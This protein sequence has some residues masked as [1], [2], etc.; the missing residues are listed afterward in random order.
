LFNFYEEIDLFFVELFVFLDLKWPYL[1]V[2]WSQLAIFLS[3]GGIFVTVLD[4]VQLPPKLVLSV[5]VNW[6]ISSPRWICFPG[7]VF[8]GH[9]QE[10]FIA[11]PVLLIEDFAI[12]CCFPR[13]RFPGWICLGAAGSPWPARHQQLVHAYSFLPPGSGLVFLLHEDFAAR[14]PDFGPRAYHRDVPRFRFPKSVLLL[15]KTRWSLRRL[16]FPPSFAAC[17]WFPPPLVFIAAPGAVPKIAFSDSVLLP[18][19]HTSLVF[20]SVF[21]LS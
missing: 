10:S 7:R 9:V 8:I 2:P 5:C 6:E 17:C 20:S 14:I 12:A 13:S 16:I 18:L 4:F 11:P 15:A 3:R 1:S 21:F 19:K